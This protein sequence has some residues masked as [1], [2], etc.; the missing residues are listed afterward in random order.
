MLPEELDAKVHLISAGF[1]VIGQRSAN[2]Q[3]FSSKLLVSRSESDI[4]C[5]IALIYSKTEKNGKLDADSQLIQW[6]GQMWRSDLR[7]L[8][9]RSR[10]RI[11]TV[12]S[13]C[14]GLGTVFFIF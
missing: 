3:L 7:A 11:N 1:P 4:K 12:P 8:I 6:I 5:V 10:G 9:L 14:C 2:L 13:P